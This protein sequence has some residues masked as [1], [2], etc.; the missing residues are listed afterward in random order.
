MTCINLSFLVFRS[1]VAWTSFI[2]ATVSRREAIFVSQQSGELT[3][4]HTIFKQFLATF[5]NNCVL[6]FITYR[7]SQVINGLSN[8]IV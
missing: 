1:I 5:Q 7:L 4:I 8:F 2:D 3:A 6:G